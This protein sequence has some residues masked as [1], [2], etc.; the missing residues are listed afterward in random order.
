[1]WRV[2][3]RTDCI[4]VGG[5]VDVDIDELQV[6]AAITACMAQPASLSARRRAIELLARACTTPSH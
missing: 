3:D 6:D 1:M 4:R 5:D 2:A